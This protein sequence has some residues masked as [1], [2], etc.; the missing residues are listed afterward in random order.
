MLG[1]QWTGVIGRH[2]EEERKTGL[3]STKWDNL[4]AHEQ[5][6]ADVYVHCEQLMHF[7]WHR[8]LAPSTPSLYL[9]AAFSHEKHG[10]CILRYSDCL[11]HNHDVVDPSIDLL[12]VTRREKA[13]GVDVRFPASSRKLWRPAHAC[14]CSLEPT[15]RVG[16]AVQ[17]LE[18]PQGS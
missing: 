14:Y 17:G 4:L 11:C 3:N 12:N 18:A 7:C 10:L 5:T 13:G 9:T 16:P 6:P 1:A 15:V 2:L 8:V